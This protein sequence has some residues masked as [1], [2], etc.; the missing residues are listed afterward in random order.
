MENLADDLRF[1]QAIEKN[2]TYRHCILVQKELYREMSKTSMTFSASVY[3][4]NMSSRKI[5]L[6]VLT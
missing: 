3:L 6:N 1:L 5:A 4:G 2:S